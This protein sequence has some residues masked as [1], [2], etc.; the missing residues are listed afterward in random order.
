MAGDVQSNR[1][2]TTTVT[3]PDHVDYPNFRLTFDP[4][5]IQTG[6]KIRLR[7]DVL[8]ASNNIATDY[9]TTRLVIKDAPVDSN[10][11]VVGA[12]HVH[13]NESPKVITLP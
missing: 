10:M 8:D 12:L 5:V 13:F 1:I 6:Y 2:T 3:V 11:Q 7:I 9:G 4:G